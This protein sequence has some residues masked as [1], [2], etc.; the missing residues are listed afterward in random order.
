MTPIERVSML[1]FDANLDKKTCERVCVQTK[2]MFHIKSFLIKFF[3][4]ISW[5]KKDIVDG[6]FIVII[7]IILLE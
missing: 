7:E 1:N 3:Y 2:M 5:S 4:Y 6:L